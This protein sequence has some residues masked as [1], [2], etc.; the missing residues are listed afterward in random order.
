MRKPV[1]S[2]SD[3]AQHLS[4]VQP[5]KFWIKEVEELIYL[6]S[7]NKALVKY[8]VNVQLICTFVFAYAKS[9]FSHHV[10]EL[11]L[12]CLIDNINDELFLQAKK[13]QVFLEETYGGSM[14]E[15]ELLLE[16][17]QISEQKPKK[18]TSKYTLFPNGRG[19]G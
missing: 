4:A 12:T 16:N 13:R 2:V 11:V 18:Q 9:G 1:F 8:L 7:K 10:A 15:L 3:H 6:C 19:L 17:F 14:R 5:Q